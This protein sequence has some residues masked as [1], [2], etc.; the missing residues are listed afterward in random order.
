MPATRYDWHSKGESASE[1]RAVPTYEYACKKCGEHLEVHQSFSDPPLTKCPACRGPLR[2]VFGNI[3]ITFKGSGFYKTDSRAGNGKGPKK[4]AD[5]RKDGEK[6]SAGDGASSSSSSSDA[7]T[8]SD[9]GGKADKKDKPSSGK[10]PAAKSP[11]T[12]PAAAA[13]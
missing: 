4:D 1:R 6:V 12:S 13:S 2:K 3:A 11:P 10:T 5:T 9:T 8:T 7:A